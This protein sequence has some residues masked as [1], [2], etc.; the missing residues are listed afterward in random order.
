MCAE[1][2]TP[3]PNS[4]AADQARFNVKEADLLIL[5]CWP[6]EPVFH[7][8]HTSRSLLNTFQG[9]RLV[10]TISALSLCH[11]PEHQSLLVGGFCTFL[12]CQF[13]WL[14]PRE[15]LLIAWLWKPGELAFLAPWDCNN[16]CLPERSSYACLVPQFLLLLPGDIATFQL[17]GCMLEMTPSGA[18]VHRFHRTVTNIERV[19]QQLPENN[20]H[21][22]LK[23]QFLCLPLREHIQITWFWWPDRLLLVV[24]Q[25]CIYLDTF[26]S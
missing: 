3:G 20:L 10:G 13:L 24:P 19:L 8:T 4:E 17:L 1:I 14:L 9:W 12:V 18:Y 7:L 22:H 15:C 16:W 11:A 6:E 25:D 2:H 26:K 23:P 21:T 5:K